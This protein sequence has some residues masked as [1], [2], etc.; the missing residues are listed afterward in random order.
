MTAG[1]L[2]VRLAIEEVET[3]LRELE[4]ELELLPSTVV[5][6]VMVTMTVAVDVSVLQ[7]VCDVFVTAGAVTVD[8]N[9]EA[10]AR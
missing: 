3:G 1:G 6:E 7:R 5:S 2:D 8:V 9:V 10:V 4:L